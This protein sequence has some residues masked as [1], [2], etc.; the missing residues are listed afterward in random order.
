MDKNTEA[1]CD[2]LSEPLIQQ[3]QQQLQQQGGA[4]MVSCGTLSVSL[5]VVEE[6]WP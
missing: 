5:M 4:V 3:L 1:V 2:K 6:S